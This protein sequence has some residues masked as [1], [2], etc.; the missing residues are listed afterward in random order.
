ML[1]MGLSSNYVAQVDIPA[2]SYTM[3]DD[4]VDADNIP[5]Q[6]K[7]PVVFNPENA[8]LTLWKVDA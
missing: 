3:Q 4:G 7:V 8:T 5:K 2:R 6:K 1:T